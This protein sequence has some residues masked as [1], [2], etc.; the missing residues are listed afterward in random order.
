MQEKVERVVSNFGGFHAYL[1]KSSSPFLISNQ[2]CSFDGQPETQ[3]LNFIYF[4][5]YGKVC[6]G[7]A[8]WRGHI[9]EL[10]SKATLKLAEHNAKEEVTLFLGCALA[11]QPLGPA[12]QII[13]FILNYSQY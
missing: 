10:K 2:S 7:Y 3:I 8:K 5:V 13:F 11:G 4:E 6:P 12:L 9:V 1:V